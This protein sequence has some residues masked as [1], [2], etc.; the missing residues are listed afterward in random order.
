MISKLVNLHGVF[1]SELQ[2]LKIVLSHRH[3]AHY[4]LYNEHDKEVM[5]ALLIV[6]APRSPSY[7]THPERYL[8]TNVRRGLRVVLQMTAWG[9]VIYQIPFSG[10][11]L[12]RISMVDRR[13]GQRSHQKKRKNN[14]KKAP[15]RH[16]P[17]SSCPTASWR[18]SASEPRPVAAILLS[19]INFSLL[20]GGR[21]EKEEKEETVTQ[22]GS[23]RWHLWIRGREPALGH[24]RLSSTSPFGKNAERGG[25]VLFL[26][27]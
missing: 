10:V 11:W 20:T 16:S 6:D 25:V 21:W 27:C 7:A 2:W 9:L 24:T 13:S 5:T 4:F 12:V 17:N 8:I 1:L 26:A 23:L 19:E 18:H 3:S 14:K 15:L 22:R